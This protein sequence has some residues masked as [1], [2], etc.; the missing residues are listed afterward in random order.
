MKSQKSDLDSTRLTLIDKALQL[1]YLTMQSVEEYSEDESHKRIVAPN[2]CPNCR[3]TGRL[4]ALGYYPRYTTRFKAG[5]L[6][7]Q[8]RRFRCFACRRTTSFL[9]SFLQPYRF[10]LNETIEAYMYGNLNRPDVLRSANRLKRYGQQYIRWLP[11]LRLHL[12][13]PL[14]HLTNRA[15][16]AVWKT[17]L[18]W[19][20][21]LTLTTL[22]LTRDH[23]ITMFGQYRC[24]LPNPP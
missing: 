12:R 21:G 11:E 20:G 6:K 24:H 19:G 8:I 2:C 22:L 14:R 13:T 23:Q 3:K 17:L 1:I 16:E 9:P 7:I 18:R 10:V 15:A 5:T 4:K